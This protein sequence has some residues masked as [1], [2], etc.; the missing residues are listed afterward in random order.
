MNIEKFYTK[1]VEI[2]ERAKYLNGKLNELVCSKKFISENY[3]IKINISLTASS[4]HNNNEKKLREIS[5]PIDII[6]GS[7]I[8]KKFVLDK[9][10][11]E[12]KNITEQL[13]NLD[14]IFIDSSKQQKDDIDIKY[15]KGTKFTNSFRD[16]IYLVS[17]NPYVI[18]I[19]YPDG[20]EIKEVTELY[21]DELKLLEINEKKDVEY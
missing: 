7:N 10:D 12:I 9:L 21:L 13:N 18:E 19:W 8:T 6:L 4:Y 20:K 3:D 16:T 15:N 14:N 2:Y 1:E 17:V 11:T 5:L